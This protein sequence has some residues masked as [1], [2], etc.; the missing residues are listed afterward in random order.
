MPRPRALGKGQRDEPL[1]AF[2]KG[3]DPRGRRLRPAG[4]RDWICGP[5]P[6]AA[7]PTAPG[8]YNT[9]SLL[10]KLRP[11]IFALR[12]ARLFKTH[13]LWLLTRGHGPLFP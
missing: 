12:A 7:R 4:G 10:Q 6:G 1:A 11:A 3:S 2:V 9:P 5:E 8:N 13:G